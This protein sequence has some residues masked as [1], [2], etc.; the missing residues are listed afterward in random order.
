MEWLLDNIDRMIQNG[1]VLIFCNHIKTCND[2]GKVFTEFA[3][4]IDKV[5]IHGDKIQQERT[6]IIRAF[7][8]DV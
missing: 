1:K 6:R 7:K 8:K 5:V 4:K 3:P 2:L